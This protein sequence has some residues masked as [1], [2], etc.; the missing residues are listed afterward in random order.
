MPGGPGSGQRCRGVGISGCLG[1]LG[2]LPLGRCGW[3]DGE[4]V[5]A[6]SGVCCGGDSAAGKCAPGGSRGG[7]PVALGHCREG[8][9]NRGK[10]R[11]RSGGRSYL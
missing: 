5:G 4:P 2:D 9:V 7:V 6:G 8:G 3:V 1:W 10:L 11:P